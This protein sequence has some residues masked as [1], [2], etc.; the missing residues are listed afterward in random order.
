MKYLLLTLVMLTTSALA[1]S[2]NIITSYSVEAPIKTHNT[3]N[4]DGNAKV[5]TSPFRDNLP[6][7]AKIGIESKTGNFTYG[8]GFKYQTGQDI[9]NGYSY[10]RSGVYFEL[11]YDH[12]ILKC[13]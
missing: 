1:E 4:V 6:T 5:G 13:K 2:M 9:F 3:F 10:D 11:K 12:C 8:S 7:I